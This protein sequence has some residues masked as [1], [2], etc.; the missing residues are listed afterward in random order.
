MALFPFSEEQIISR[1]QSDNPWWVNGA[2]DDFYE[3]F[4]PRLYFNIF[5]PLVKTTSVNRATVLMGPRRVGKTVMI[6]HSIKKL[7]EEGVSPQKILYASIET[8]IYNNISPEYL[9]TLA[10]KAS[11]DLVSEG[12]YIFFDEIQYLK[13]WEVHL[14]NL[15]DVFRK[16]KF[17]ASGSAAAALKLKSNESGAGRFT[18]FMLPPLTFYEYIHLKNL[19]PL[20]KPDTINWKGNIASFSSATNIS[21]LNKCFVEYVNF[22][23]YPE[24]IFNQEIQSNPG[25][26]MRADIIDKVLLRDLPGLYGIQDVQELN[27]LF[28]TIAWNSGRE[29]SMDEL[30][31]NSGVK[32]STLRQ[33]LFYLEAAFLVH[34]VKRVDQNAGRFQRENFFKIYLTNPSLRS[35]LFAP[36]GAEDDGMGAL[37]ETAIFSQ[38]MQRTSFIPYYARWKNGEVDLININRKK[39]KPDWAVEIKW[40]NRFFEAPN[41][42]R[43]L[44]TFCKENN[45]SQALAT[46]ID[47]TGVKE[48]NGIQIQFIPASVY[49]YNVGKN[50]IEGLN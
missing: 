24:V 28:T 7:I 50:T 29:C 9:F 46:T 14:K 20:I 33:Y 15:V 38:W 45:L 32:K 49:A 21:E 19:T 31:K 23:G 11:G 36:L 10:K 42:L 3:A 41:E 6:Y 34:I 16:T 22:G 47:K 48:C 12:W 27:S 44:V 4:E 17:I 26:Y 30:S 1:L 2:L 39:N 8:P 43:S 25:R 40:S 13:D 18:D 37:M 35:A 5:Y